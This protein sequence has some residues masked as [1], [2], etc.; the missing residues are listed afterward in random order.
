MTDPLGPAAAMSEELRRALAEADA[1]YAASQVA[2]TVWHD[3]HRGD[4]G[5]I[6]QMEARSSLMMSINERI[7]EEGWNR[8]QAAQHLG[9]TD[10]QAS[11]LING[12]LSKFSL[13]ALVKM[14]EPVGLVI[15]VEARWQRRRSAIAAL[16]G[17][18]T[19]V[20]EPGYLDTLRQDWPE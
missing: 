18:L 17:S 20:Y 8:H 11:A 5:K 7:R 14:L 3:L 1:I 9:I 16:S 4:P 6:A 10:P 12:E 15:S 19:G 2:D 13:A